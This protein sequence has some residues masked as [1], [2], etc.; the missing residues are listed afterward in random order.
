M[1]FDYIDGGMIKLRK[2]ERRKERREEK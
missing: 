1:I 2:Q